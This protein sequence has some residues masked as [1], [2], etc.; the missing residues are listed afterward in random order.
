[1]QFF[2][3]LLLAAS[4]VVSAD[5]EHDRHHGSSRAWVGD[6]KNLVA[7]GAGERMSE[8]SKDLR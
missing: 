4:A 3:I 1:M 8:P 6:F 2:A 7:F 5:S